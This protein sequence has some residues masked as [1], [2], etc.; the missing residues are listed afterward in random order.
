MIMT[1]VCY[2]ESIFARPILNSPGTS[3]DE[4]FDYT[5]E[6]IQAEGL[7]QALSINKELS[8][9]V[10]AIA[11]QRK[12]RRAMLDERYKKQIADLKRAIETS[13]ETG[14]ANH[15]SQIEETTRAIQA[16]H[17]QKWQSLKALLTVKQQA[18]YLLYQD[19]LQRELQ[20]RAIKGLQP[21]TNDN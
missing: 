3:Q 20:R 6:Q 7:R 16:L 19:A 2:N 10:S 15:L 17:I 1:L 4:S 9:Q 13:D 8:L 11:R 12:Q 5:I 18:R 21:G 14:L